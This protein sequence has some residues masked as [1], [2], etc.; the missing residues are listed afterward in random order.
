MKASD[1]AIL[2]TSED[3]RDA[4][5]FWRGQVG[6]GDLFGAL[7]VGASR[8][9]IHH[10]IAVT[11]DAPALAALGRLA[12]DDLGR[13]AV[14]TAGISLAICRYFNRPAS[15]LRS[16]LLIDET[17]TTLNAAG[18]LP[19]VFSAG[20]SRTIGEYLD[21]A[22]AIVEQSYS[23]QDYP[24]DEL[25]EI[26]HGLDLRAR[27][28]FSIA[29]RAIHGALLDPPA[30]VHF[31]L[32][33]L[34]RGEI[35]IRF[36]PEALDPFLASG[37]ASVVNTAFAAFAA[38]STPIADIDRV[39]REQRE[40]LLVDWNRTSASRPFK[41]AHSLFEERASLTPDAIAIRAGATSLSYRELNELANRLAHHLL[42]AAGPHASSVGIWMDRSPWMV[43]A[44]FG[45]LKAGLAYVPIDA[46][47]P[48]DRAAYLVRDS[49][50]STLLIDAA[51]IPA[52]STLGVAAVVA[53]RAVPGASTNPGVPVA[54]ADLA[55]MIYTSGS[56]GE[57]KGCEIE[58]HSLTNYLQW[59]MHYYWS[60]ADTGSMALFTP[61]SFD[62][63]VPSLFCPLLRGR[64]LVVY[65][66]DAA[67]DDVLHQQF[68][69]ASSIDTIKLTPSHIRVLDPAR[70]GATGVRLLIVGGEALTQE[71][72]ALAHQIDPRIR[73][74]N[75][76][77]PT[78]ATVGCI[79]KEIAGGEPILI[80]RPIDNTRV[81]VLDD[82]QR[83]VAVGIRG[84]ICIG[85]E[86]VARGYHNR[87]ALD[88]ARFLPDPFVAGERIYRTGDIGR[89]LP[90]GDL[91]C[92]GRLDTQLKL[93]GYRIEP[94]EIEA[95]L[96]KWTGIEEAVVVERGGQLI[97]FFVGE[98]SVDHAAIKRELARTL[99]QYMVP[100]VFVRLDELPL[101]TNG[102]ID[103]ARLAASSMSGQGR[104]PYVAPRTA[105]EQLV[106]RIWE[107]VL[108]LE[109]VGIDED[110]FELGGHSLR[111]MTIMRR[112]HAELGVDVSIGEVLSR[113]T[114]ASLA[115]LL[116]SKS[117]SS[118]RPIAPVPPADHYAV[119]LGQRRLW[120]ID[121]IDHDSPAYNVSSTFDLRGP[122]DRAAL[123]AAFTTLVARHESLRT[124]FVEINE[125]PRQRIL[126]ALQ[127]PIEYV[128]LRGDANPEERL[129]TL[130]AAQA[131]APFDLERAPLLRVAVF[132]LEDTRSV[133]A[134]T[135]HHI[136]SDEWSLRVLIADA[137][138]FYETRE[139][140]PPLP[141]QYK[142]YAAWQRKAFADGTMSADRDYWLTKLAGAVPALDVPA[143]FP[144]PAMPTYRGRHHYGRI[145][146]QTR[147][148]LRS[149]G[150]A[151]GASVFMTLL[152]IVK[153]LL[154]R[155]TGETDIWV[156]SPIAGRIHADLANQ[157]GFF[158]NTLVLRD[159]VRGSTTFRDLLTA[160]K[161]TSEEAYEHQAFPFDRLVD[162]LNVPRDLS[163]SPLFDVMVAY[164]NDADT[165][166]P[167]RD[168][169]VDELQLDSGVSKFDLTFAFAE[170]ERGLDI[171]IEYSTDLF[172]DVRIER[173]TADLLAI[174]EAVL[175][176]AAVP[177]SKI[178]V[179]HAPS[180]APAPRTHQQDIARAARH[181]SPRN[182]RELLLVTLL[183]PLLG[184]ERLD[185]MD[186][187]FHAGGDSI[188]AV[189]LVN[190]LSR[191]GWALRVR[192]LFET[193]R[194]EDLAR[195]LE[196]AAARRTQHP[197]S[198][199]AP[200]TP[201]QRWF[202]ETQPDGR[203]HFNQSVMLK[204]DRRIDDVQ[205]HAMGRALV[206]QHDALRLRF[207]VTGEAI[208]QFFG[209]AYDPATIHDLSGVA[210]A[211]AA[212]EQLAAAAQAGLD[213]EHGPLARFV[214]F[215]L[216]DGD[217]LLA[218]IHHLAVDGVSW[219]ILL[220][221][222][223]T[224]LDQI[225]RG[226]PISLG[227]KSDSFK[228][229]AT[230]LE[231]RV[232]GASAEET[233]W[234]EIE[235][236]NT[237]PLPYD[238][239]APPLLLEADTSELR[240][241][242]SAEDTEALRSRVHRAYNTRT[243][244]VLLAALAGAL[245]EWAGGAV[246]VDLEAHGRDSLDGLDVSRTVG[247]F[248]TIYP[249][250]L[251]APGGDDPGAQLVAVKE[252]LRRTPSH[253]EGYGL[254]RQG[255]P[256][257]APILFNFL[258]QFDSDIEE[259]SIA[260]EGR[261]PEQGPRARLT[262]DIVFGGWVSEKRLNL[263]LRYSTK[264]F[265]ERTVARLLDIYRRSLEACIAHCRDRAT[266]G[267]TASDFRYRDATTPALID[268]IGLDRVE[269][270]YPLSP[271][272][273]GMLYHSVLAAG[274]PVYFEQFT[275][276]ISGSLDLEAFTAAWER[277][278]ARHT[279]L[280][281]AFY[282]NQVEQPVQVVFASVD[283]PWIVHDWRSLPET[284]RLERF[285]TFLED[286]RRKGFALDAP[287]LMRFALI[288]VTDDRYQFCWS[289]HHLVLDGWSTA[290]ILKE[291]FASYRTAGDTS[292]LPATRP[293]GDYID[294]L[295]AQD[296]A[297]ADAYWRGQLGG[298]SSPTP[299]P[300]ATTMGIESAPFA[301]TE[302]MLSAEV[303]R[304][305]S[306]AAREHAL[307][308]NTLARGV[309]ALVLAH[310]AGRGEVVYG[311]TVA[312]RPASM[313]DV[314]AIVGVFIN[315]L[316]IR[317][318]IDG[319]APLL[320]WLRQLQIEQSDLDQYAYSA[321]ADIQ[322]CSAVPAR[323]PLF[324][325][326]LVFENYPVDQSLDPGKMDLVV[327]A[328][329]MREQTNYPLTLSVVPGDELLLRL[330]FDTSR[331][332]ARS[333]QGLLGEIASRFEAFA[334]DPDGTVASLLTL[335]SDDSRT[336]HPRCRYQFAEESIAAMQRLAT[337]AGTPI[338][339]VVHAAVAILCFRLSG[340]EDLACS[341]E[342][343]RLAREDF[344]GDDTFSGVIRKLPSSGAATITDL[345]FR[346]VEDSHPL[347]VEVTSATGRF[348]GAFLSRTRDHLV[349]L[350]AAIGSNP[351]RAI[352][353]LDLLPPAERVQLLERFNATGTEWGDERTVVQHFEAQASRHPDRIALSLPAIGREDMAEDQ[354]WTYGTLN[355][356]TNQLARL[357]VRDH[358]VG[359]NVIVGVLAERSFEMVLGLYAIE[360]A[361]GAYVPLDPAYPADLLHFMMEDS[362]ARV[363]LTQDKF[364]QLTADYDGAVIR[365]DAGWPAIAGESEEN[366]P[367]RMTG[368]DLAYVIYT[369]GSTGKPKGAMNTHRG[370][371]NRLLWMQDA[372]RLGEDD[373][374]L[375]KTPFSFDVSVWEFFWPL[376]V[377][378]RL[379]IAAP[380]GHR[381]AAYLAALIQDASITTLH[382][383]PSM[384]QAFID[385]PS[386]AACRSLRR[387]VCSGEAIT[388]ELL[389]R[390]SA[391]VPVPL[392]NL[393]GPTEAAVDVTSWHCDLADAGTMVPIGR[394]IANIQLYILDELLQPVPLGATGE[395][396]L[397][398]VG[399]GRGY[400]NRPDLTATRFIPDPFR[401]SPTA[402]LYRT[403]DLAR[404]RDN[405]LV[406]FLGRI[407]HQVKLRGFRIELP[408]IESVLLAHPAIHECVVVVREDQPGNKRLIAYVVLNA[409]H[410][411]VPADVRAHLQ[412]MLP[413]HMVPSLTIALPD[414]PRLTNGKIDRKALP[415]PELTAP[416]R[417]RHVPPRNPT[418]QRLVRV[419]E[420]VLGHRAIGVTDDFFEL[421]GH[422]ILAVKLVSAI[423]REF[424]RRVPLA[425]LLG[426]S[427]VERLA[428]ALQNPDDR[429]DWRPLVTIRPGAALPPLFLLP[430]AGGNVIYFHALAQQ[431]ETL[432]PIYALQ[433]IGLDGRTPPLA[434]VD[435]I[436]AINIKELERVWPDGP[437]I[438]AGHSF[439]GRVAFEMAQQLR[440]RGREVAM[441]AMFDTPAPTFDPIAVGVGWQ[442]ADWLAKIAREIEEF[443]GIALSVTVDELRLFSLDDQL[444]LTVDR[445]QSAGG[446]VPGA[447]TDQLRGYLQVYRANSQAPFLTYDRATRI[448]MALF[449][450]RESDP[451]LEATPESL[452]ALTAQ[453][454]W[455][456]DRF[457][458]G[459]VRVFDVPGAH[460]SMLA[461][462]HVTA[463]ARALDEALAS[464][465]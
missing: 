127:L 425:Q 162:A 69:A 284:A 189:Q 176:D 256:S 391:R 158:V 423:E 401:P 251:D 345:S 241:T 246:R 245:R 141:I 109:R 442:D 73:V 231:A 404:Y 121:R 66:Q 199:E 120:L 7:A 235:Q 351:G 299:L 22:T 173:M 415:A 51:R 50:I 204:F 260:D 192:D 244:D 164:D 290:I 317:V 295:R 443:F 300:L 407:D 58:H 267:R 394:P 110:F 126:P 324:E 237:K 223:R 385:E 277:V 96:R 84:E 148:R 445:M 398:G 376:M 408:E 270:L 205:M 372:Y 8:Q 382:F 263:T 456:W 179:G 165:A 130:A 424:G 344:G 426:Y 226:E 326:L 101:T 288:R 42:G 34:D 161:R 218:V 315:T 64:T 86:G 294:W 265:E 107:E 268:R 264:R 459:S 447:D 397:G 417:R 301:I 196:P 435:A 441:L 239:D 252:R 348:D 105:H 331:Y 297:Q 341:F 170:S 335:G 368:D 117:P 19:L 6:A 222:L 318:R 194:I 308:L 266:A 271:M 13:F 49:G 41:A 305:L 183:E 379:V 14:A 65:P 311:A 211:S 303:S 418:E 83:P 388:P 258:G 463:L 240:I 446:W 219:R 25:G 400:L 45:A 116:P 95:A 154:H 40:Q 363:I 220:D 142:D 427:T 440:R 461:P 104:R 347:T 314:E 366:L 274:T 166:V 352:A 306:T 195:K 12:N 452:A 439:G 191:R 250:V 416:E 208:T 135:L 153:V 129:R 279:A 283:L 323:T 355:A 93:R 190:R 94:G 291:V 46:D 419:W 399:V 31:D 163:R 171:E 98:D 373:H 232:A 227:E 464:L 53:D 118:V 11:L 285:N 108:R 229:W 90:T 381:D 253:G 409:P 437:C 429:F 15:L 298:V 23:F 167:S 214:L 168:L 358:A 350:V 209:D 386:I 91:E 1:Y 375:Q 18:E 102:K 465:G 383:V 89:W 111:A 278:I 172:T 157:I 30:P 393:Y 80:G 428:V 304:Q 234:R 405:G 387:V 380:G 262:H 454:S 28:E 374:V 269:D 230:A 100:D 224:A 343:S 236:A 112:I 85:G 203:H 193:P 286:D 187:F 197:V 57:P 47:C 81:Y 124:S 340:N 361:G 296:S 152:A 26:E 150:A 330:S 92:F 327:D 403:G 360:K 202:F 39:P 336:T 122:L 365:L 33:R 56:T 402:Q 406:D 159:E 133:I 3:Y 210:N 353:R 390:Y 151:Q 292:A 320:D 354:A 201:I 160:V 128:D 328:I 389:R 32:D 185:V 395:L 215:H 55:Y 451:D 82:E 155:Y 249:I 72:V 280:R 71:Q 261:G 396:Y 206:E 114:V 316:P 177:I 434:T 273:Q 38:L 106:A 145:D 384:L 450:A 289:A 213:L 131:A 242:L 233:W 184:H 431:L 367:S 156:G 334:Q 248:T 420:G 282:W 138:Q 310:Y 174:V 221:D 29:S 21:H 139:A 132:Q 97:A 338:R 143:D 414:L 276:T 48:P 357:L 134:L 257:G 17:A 225:A 356:R 436:A 433:A 281:S 307:T 125:E 5:A 74:I 181:V 70:I 198:G 462:P 103:R 61:L 337:A 119:S 309:W 175:A 188:K 149:L 186:N 319:D 272:Q 455:G 342:S 410:V 321:L 146:A 329:E 453:H 259:L 322:R 302:M 147:A 4:T 228:S 412:R 371:A 79:I 24:I 178:A 243:N 136:V 63:T 2:A 254:L 87:P 35:V 238:F 346:I 115:E 144:R 77:G 247:W 438:L 421:G 457:A 349:Q 293:F 255:R 333:A 313:P 460:L 137:I 212:L 339:S 113:P 75:E 422:S 59:A 370:I 364:A 62:L 68:Q 54:P 217:R 458:D 444:S 413:E 362:G 36:D 432:R 325:S 430:G 449:K 9:A 16:P 411:A 275:C 140:L 369:S 180:M 76:Y 377:G 67:I 52:A 287:P 10:S 43:V 216:P 392:H 378:A 78:E 20:S 312:G 44:V 123:T 60:A 169:T 88:A 200:L 99:P 27:G 359:P 37:L 332:D 207:R 448:P 182:E